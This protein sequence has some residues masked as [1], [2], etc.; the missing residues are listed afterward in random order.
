MVARTLGLAVGLGV[1]AF[2]MVVGGC[3]SQQQVQ[4]SATVSVTEYAAAFDATKKVLRE[5]GFSIDRQDARAGVITTRAKSTGGFATPWDREQT[6]VGDEIDDAFSRQARLV[7]VRFGARAGG[8]VES[9]DVDVRTQP[10]PMSVTVSVQLLR[11]ERP[12]WR[13]ESTAINLSSY[14][15][16]PALARRGL[17]PTYDVV[18][19]S[20]DPLAARLANEIERAASVAVAVVAV[21]GAG[22]GAGA[23][24]VAQTAA[25][26]A[27]VP[28]GGSADALGA[29][30]ARTDSSKK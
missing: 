15:S 21:A 17:E 3:S 25:A 23:A 5:Y 11:R 22:A 8:A 28:A 4:Q 27:A 13:V 16:D 12:G 2:A 14:T 26:N 10:G 7:R 24:A 20:D 18:V 6:S 9:V 30:G 19:G 1:G 29:G